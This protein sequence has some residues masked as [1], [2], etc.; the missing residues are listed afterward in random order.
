MK[1]V[2]VH[3]PYPI[4]IERLDDIVEAR[5][6]PEIL[7]TG[8]CLDGISPAGLR[9]VK[10]RLDEHGLAVT[11]HGPFM[12]LNPGAVDE[13]VRGVTVDR[14][15]QLF[16]A[17]DIL[18][19]RNVVLHHTYDRWRYDGNEELWLGQSLKTWPQF[20][21]RARRIGA[22]IAVENV[23]EGYPHPIKALVE[24][25]DSPHFKV[26]FDIG[27]WNV[28]SEIPM[29]EWLGEIGEHIAEFHI[30]DNTGEGDDHMAIG[31]GSINFS[32]L[33]G[34]ISAYNKRDIVYT[35]EAHSEEVLWRSLR[36]LGP[37]L[38]G[39]C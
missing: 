20:V 13:R 38:R 32:D 19:P 7:F 9:A 24:A 11:V 6:N 27:H 33:F 39:E 31:D 34:A 10:R 2:H 14:Y 5:L 21:E 29:E 22:V 28:F 18:M 36:N 17:A 37:M 8:E 30:H 25:I 15:V 35:I 23:F 3:I 12:D 1:N 4:L 26:C 16:H